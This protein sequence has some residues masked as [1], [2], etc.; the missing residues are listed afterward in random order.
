MRT[1]ARVVSAVTILQYTRTV[2]AMPS[3]ARSCWFL[4][5]LTPALTAADWN[6]WRG[7]DRNGVSKDTSALVRELPPSGL[8]GLWESDPIPSDHDGG[9]GSPV[10]SDGRVYLSLVWHKHVP[11]EQRVIEDEHLVSLGYRDTKLLGA[12]LT[13]E[14]EKTRKELSAGLRGETLQNWIRQWVQDH[15]NA[16]Q[17]L[18]LGS[19]AEWRLGQKGAAVDLEVLKRIQPKVGQVFASHEEMVQWLTQTG[20]EPAVQEKLLKLVPATI[21]EAEDVVICL[22]LETGKTLWK[23][24]VPGKPVD[25]A[26]SSTCAVVDGTVYAMG[27]AQVQAVD[28]VT[29][30]VRWRR[31]AGANQGSSPLVVGERLWYV[32]GGMSCLST[33]DGSVIWKNPKVKGGHSSPVL[34]S[35]SRGG[36]TLLCSSSG[37]LVGL[38]PGSGTVRWELAGGG[39]STPVTQGDWLVFLS[40]AKDAG[41][42]CFRAQPQGPPQRQWNQWWLASRYTASPLIYDDHVYLT[43][44]GRHLCVGLEDGRVRWDEKVESTISSPVLADGRIWN[45]EQNGLFLRSIVADPASYKLAG[46][47]KVEALWCPTPLLADGRLLLRKKDRLVCLDLRQP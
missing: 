16:E 18:I 13:A 22:D 41:L 37:K 1:E 5:L 36:E 28:A 19:W 33:K 35:S 14:L 4:I 39:P 32:A 42:Q 27:S 26:A 30:E 8:P 10:V 6:Q 24:S 40:D 15:F 23:Q 46:R 47:I 29:G 31:E 44:G 3:L 34:W 11:S 7:S 38:D 2:A 21:K 9:H 20:I 17:R 45:L 25:R 43:E 12:D